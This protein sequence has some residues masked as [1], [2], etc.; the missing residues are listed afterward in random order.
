VR[1]TIA[2]IHTCN[3]GVRSGR[4]DPGDALRI[5]TTSIR[6]LFTGATPA[7]RTPP[8]GER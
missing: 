4:I 2:L 8:D 6:D 7:V 1:A 5:L 3:D